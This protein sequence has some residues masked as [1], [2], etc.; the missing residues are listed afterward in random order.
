[1]T[2]QQ[3]ADSDARSR[4]GR[5]PLVTPLAMVPGGLPSSGKQRRKLRKI[6]ALDCPLS[7][8]VWCRCGNFFSRRPASWF[9]RRPIICGCRRRLVAQLPRPTA[10][11]PGTAPCSLP[12]PSVL[13]HFFGRS[14]P[15]RRRN[16]FTDAP[17][18]RTESPFT[19][20]SRTHAFSEFQG[21]CCIGPASLAFPR[22]GDTF[23]DV[24]ADHRNVLGRR[25][26]LMETEGLV[27]SIEPR[28]DSLRN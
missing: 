3:S 20:I 1:M 16:G 15:R 22:P 13:K 12:I 10:S 18:G 28:P 2:E 27:S 5:C 17:S 21:N 9:Y 6:G 4:D 7:F 14:L 8:P 25:R 11:S 19:S 24:G 23:I 26:G